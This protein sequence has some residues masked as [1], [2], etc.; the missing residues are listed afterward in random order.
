MVELGRNAGST[1]AL[2]GVLRADAD[3]LAHDAADVDVALRTL[4]EKV[5]RAA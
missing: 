2:A 1:G 5:R 3:V 4:I